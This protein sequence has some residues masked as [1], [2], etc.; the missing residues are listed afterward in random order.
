MVKKKNYCWEVCHTR[1]MTQ[2]HIL[3]HKVKWS[4]IWRFCINSIQNK[5]HQSNIHNI[6]NVFK[7]IFFRGR[8]FSSTYF[9]FYMKEKNMLFTQ[10]TESLESEGFNYASCFSTPHIII[11]I[12]LK[13]NACL[14][15]P[16][17]TPT[18]E[19]SLWIQ[20]SKHKR[21]RSASR[22]DL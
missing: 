12:H 14:Y 16:Y 4:F 15:I 13:S 21:N 20:T 1:D 18:A 5:T 3:L 8:I 19:D 22:S 9:Y 17:I 10:W 2:V 6:I 7:I 11:S